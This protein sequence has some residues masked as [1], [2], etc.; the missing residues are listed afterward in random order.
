MQQLGQPGGNNSYLQFS[1]DDSVYSYADPRA[2]E[3]L[4]HDHRSVAGT[5]PVPDKTQ[6]K[7]ST[8]IFQ[9]SGTKIPPQKHHAIH[10][11]LPPKNHN[12]TTKNHQVLPKNRKT[13]SKNHPKKLQLANLCP[14]G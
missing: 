3:H 10:H 4:C 14:Q 5:H 8:E 1:N 9:K 11:V 13:P 12:F 6:I 7:F 2:V